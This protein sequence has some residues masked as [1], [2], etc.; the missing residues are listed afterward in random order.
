M[1]AP[2]SIIVAGILG[3]KVVFLNAEERIWS[4]E[5]NRC[6]NFL[7]ELEIF[8]SLDETASEANL[9][10]SKLQILFLVLR[11]FGSLKLTYERYP[12]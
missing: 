5:L 3:K 7:L 2:S 4:F 1:T 6:S 9:N 11:S 8:I 12:E 10:T